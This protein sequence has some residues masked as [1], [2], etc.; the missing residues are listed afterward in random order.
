MIG[1]IDKTVVV[2]VVVLVGRWLLWVPQITSV[3][4]D[5]HCSTLSVCFPVPLQL[6]E[7]PWLVLANDM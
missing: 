1:T 2:A 4:R 6:S 5:T 7:G 3:C